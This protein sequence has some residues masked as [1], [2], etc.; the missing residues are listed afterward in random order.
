[1]SV[2]LR[3]TRARARPTLPTRWYLRQDETGSL[4]HHILPE[5]TSK[6]DP[7][8]K[9][10][11]GSNQILIKIRESGWIR[12]YRDKLPN[13][14]SASTRPYNYF[15]TSRKYFRMTLLYS[16]SIVYVSIVDT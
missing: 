7:D 15:L 10:Q 8:S 1:M 14:T 6:K 2:S 16:L 12:R 5:G 4:H 11:T 13:V 3:K 9:L